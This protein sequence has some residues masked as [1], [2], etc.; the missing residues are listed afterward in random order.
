M[1][2]TRDLIS[3]GPPRVADGTGWLGYSPP[4]GARDEVFDER[5]EVRSHWHVFLQSLK[6]LGLPQLTRRWADAR[7][8]IRENGVT[9]NVYGDPR[10]L[11]RPWQLDP[12]PLI[13]AP[14]EADALA[15]G[16]A[17]RGRLL[18]ALLRDLYGPQQTLA[19]GLLPPEF[20]YA[21]PAF[22]RSCHGAALPGGRYLHL[23]AANVGRSADGTFWVLGDRTQSPSGAGYALENRLVLSRTLPETFRDCRVQRLALFFRSLR[24]ALRGL[25]PHNRDNPRVVL[26]TP[27]PYNETYF[28]HAYLA[29]YLGYT[30]VEGGDLTVRDDRVFLKVLGGLHPVDVILRRLDDDFCDP[31]ELRPD[32]FLGV[33]G[34]VQAVRSGNVAVANAL[35]SGLLETTALL[36][37]LPQLCRHLLG[38]ELR[39]PSVPTWWCGDPQARAGV[40]DR[41]DELVIK[42]ALP[43]TRLEPVIGAELTREQRAELAGKIRARPRDYVAQERLPLS[44]T[45]VL[46]GNRLQPRHLV[47]RCYLA[48]DG[49]SFTFMPGGLTRVSASADTMVVSMQRGGGSKDTWVLSAG[50][51]STFSLLKEGGLAVELS[52][53]GSDLPSRA[54]DNLYWLGRYA[55]R[56]EG[57]TRLLRCIL[58]RLTETPGL[59]DVPELPVLLR[60]A[61]RLSECYP[62]FLGEGAAVRLAAPETELLALIHDP[63]R[64]GNLAWV[65]GALSNVAATVRDRISTDMWRVL[66]DLGRVRRSQGFFAPGGDGHGPNGDGRT[67]SGELDLLDGVVLTLAAFGGLAMESVTRGEG[68]RFLDMGRKLERALHTI[69]LLR[70]TLTTPSQPEG[71]VLEALLEIADSAMT[72]RRRYQGG[73]QADAVLDLLL[74]DETNPRSLAY[75]LAAVADDVEHLPREADRPARSP[76]Q[77]LMLS[78]LTALRLADIHQLAGFDECGGRPALEDLLVR[79]ASALPALSDAITQTYLSHLQTSRHL[80]SFSHQRD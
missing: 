43:G 40:L 25:A 26:L 70:S 10:G 69:G 72:Y 61:T 8:L 23:Y 42:P 15:A 22:L 30:L 32:S 28:E 74:A 6:D 62:G 55:E 14:A 37:F 35:G 76:E 19:R 65:L 48:A 64:R 34:L 45:P 4:A 78:S 16:L 27:G 79:L 47:L 36:A 1:S 54:A 66:R 44:T 73:V 33:P 68:W 11:E 2:D 77:R 41:L 38:E 52:R 9:Y 63:Q 20:V 56:A 51:V 58:V 5:G 50:P 39:L 18:D 60:T 75:Q 17:Q 12:I 67:L 24:D 46:V 3:P 21:N 13:I 59:T 57:L 29:R 80:G 71:P 7:H 53:G 31:L 49:D